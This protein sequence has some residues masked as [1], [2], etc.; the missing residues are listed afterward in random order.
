MIPFM[1]PSQRILPILIV[2]RHGIKHDRSYSNRV[3][4]PQHNRGGFAQH[5]PIIQR[6]LISKQLQKKELKNIIPEKMQFYFL[7]R[8]IWS[9]KQL[10]L[11]YQ[12]VVTQHIAISSDVGSFNNYSLFLTFTICIK[13]QQCLL[14]SQYQL[15]NSDKLQ[16][17]SHLDSSLKV[18]VT[19][20]HS[21]QLYDSDRLQPSSHLDSSVKVLVTRHHSTSCTTQIDY[22]LHLIQIHL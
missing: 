12:H 14:L 10:S 16:P 3:S 5:F 2:T 7:L 22:N 1:L 6:A 15:Y 18:L 11:E 8:W 9:C 17:S 13:F 4:L 21:Y 19:R 20:H